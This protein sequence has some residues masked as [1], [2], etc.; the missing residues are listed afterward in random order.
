MKESET[1]KAGEDE[2]AYQSYLMWNEV[3][4]PKYG[5]TIAPPYTAVKVSV[6]L[7]KSYQVAE[8]LA[9]MK[10]REL[11]ERMKKWRDKPN[12]KGKGI[13]TFTLPEQI[14]AAGGIPEEIFE[15]INHRKIILGMTTVFY[16]ILETLGIYMLNK[17]TSRLCMD[18]H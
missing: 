3:F 17:H 18:E 1:Y 15:S 6:E 8:W 7:E 11:A 16:L 13:T 9:N 10:D 12:R 4:A 5:A 14:I 2:A